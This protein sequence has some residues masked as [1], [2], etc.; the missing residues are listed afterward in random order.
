MGGRLL[1]NWELK[2]LSVVIAFALW[3]LAVGSG[4]SHLAVAAGVEFTGLDGDLVLV[5]RP[6]DT[7]EVE[8]E[9]ARWAV[10]RLTP[11]AVRVRVDLAETREGENVVALSPDLVQAPA[12]VTVRR[13]TP[14]RLHVVLA[15]AGTKMLWVVPRIRGAPEPGHAIVRVTAEPAAVQVKGPRSTIERRTTV[16][17]VP[18]D[19]AGRRE[20]VTHSAGLVLPE[21][22]YLTGQPRVLVT[23]EIKPEAPMTRGGREE[24]GR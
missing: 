9:A 7:A 10:A 14:A 11:G 24:P 5:G 1:A 15:S 21:S 6:R 12:G 17:T 13:V 2:L 23:V 22:V 18:V 19:T 16:E 8:L 3:L 20:T 4:K